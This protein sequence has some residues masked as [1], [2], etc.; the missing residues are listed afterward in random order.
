MP[1]HESSHPW[2]ISL[3]YVAYRLISMLFVRL[4]NTS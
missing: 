1:D 2:M 4:Q 3:V